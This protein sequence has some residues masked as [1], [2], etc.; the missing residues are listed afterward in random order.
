M[1][2]PL[3]IALVAVAQVFSAENI[4]APEITDYGPLGQTFN[5]PKLDLIS[6]QLSPTGTTIATPFNKKKCYVVSGIRK[7]TNNDLY[8]SNTREAYN[9]LNTDTKISASLEGKYSMKAS[10]DAV[11]SSISSSSEEIKGLVVRVE[12]RSAHAGLRKGCLHEIKF[13]Q[14]FLRDF[15]AL[16]T[17]ISDPSKASS[18]YDYSNFINKYGTHMVTGVIYG[19]SIYSYSFAR[20]NKEYSQKEFAIKA[21]GEF[22]GKTAVGEVGA[23]ACVGVTQKDIEKS[24][25]FEM[26]KKVVVRGGQVETRSKLL[27]ERNKELITQFLKEGKERPSPIAY[28]FSEIWNIIKESLAGAQERLRASILEQYV[29]GFV[30][31]GC[32]I[33]KFGGYT[34]QK[35][36]LEP[37][38]T[39]DRPVF[40]CLL[41]NPGCNNGDD[42]HY[43]FLRGCSCNG[44]SCV[45]NQMKSFEDGKTK[46]IATVY[47]GGWRDDHPGG[48]HY[49]AGDAMCQC[50]EH[51]GWSAIWQ[52]SGL[53]DE[54][55][56][57]KLEGSESGDGQENNEE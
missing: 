35:F 4:P 42:C 29:K 13:K 8:F 18:W 19:A 57:E 36:Q 37:D 44:D 54:P 14:R 52:N 56:S 45:E 33:Q 55:S 15:R 39:P 25:D 3:V 26:S 38:S 1:I 7:S 12:D 23:K 17:K 2:F 41:K 51:F 22:A 10:L 47:D 21:C 5:V 46:K 43:K 31:F 11:T 32:E 30:A 48:C 53:D 9:F 34:V 20:S 24:S 50:T 27:F 6:K 16:P 40:Q 28:E 49:V